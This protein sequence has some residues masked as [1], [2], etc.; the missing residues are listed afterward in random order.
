[1][2]RER[3]T[4]VHEPGE[5]LLVSAYE[6]GHP[7]LG[8]AWPAAF[9]QRAGFRPDLID[10]ATVALDNQRIDRAKLVVFSTP[11]HTASALAVRAAKRVRRRNPNARIIFTG[12]YAVLNRAYLLDGIADQ[13]LGGELEGELLAI[14]EGRSTRD[15]SLTKLD[16]PVPARSRLSPLSR[17]AKLVIAGEERLAGAVQSTRGC[18]HVCTHCPI[19]AVY[20]GRFFVVGAEVVLEDIDQLVASGA[21]HITFADPDFLNAPTHARRIA[22]ELHAAHPELTFDFTAKVEHLLAQQK[23]LPELR[24]HGCLFVISA[25]E[26]LSDRVLTI[27]DKGHTRADVYALLPVLE[28]SGIALRP[29]LLPFTPWSTL[30]DYRELLAFI[31]DQNLVA[32]VD[33]VQLSVRLLV[34]PGSLLE[35]HSEMKPHLVAFEPHRFGWTWKH[36]DPRMDALAAE[37]AELVEAMTDAK[38]TAPEIYRAIA[39]AAHAEAKFHAA[40]VLEVPRMTEPWFC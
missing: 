8:I 25:V 5:I 29:S 28:S 9:L 20:G 12:D 14:A 19:P 16:F 26:S 11:M 39:G 30:E 38:A 23:I 27:L 40:R 35:S 2:C 7:P 32:N 33:P 36:P 34:P 17:Y 24:A 13:V 1:V 15:V 10:L 3:L 31:A 18:K 22:R 4:L 37:V 21:R 6:L